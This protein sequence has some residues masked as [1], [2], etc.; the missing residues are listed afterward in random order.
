MTMTSR[1][2]SPS[3]TKSAFAFGVFAALGVVTWSG[4]GPGSESRYYCDSDGCYTCDAYGCSNVAPPQH[5][6]CS[7]QASCDPGQTCT[8]TGCATVC[9]DDTACVK[10]EVC[11][12]G[13]C[14]APGTDPGPAKECT[15]KADCGDGKTCVDS[16]CKACGGTDGPCPCAAETDCSGGLTCIAGACTAP[17]NGCKFTS[18]CENGKVCADGQCLTSC[19]SAPCAEGFTCT[20]GVCEPGTTGT[21]SCTTDPEC[22][23]GKFCDQGACVV[24]TRPKPNC[25]EDAQC[26]GTAATPKKCLGGFCKYTFTSDQYC[27]TIDSRIGYCAK[28]GVCRTQAEASAACVQPT[29]CAA[30]QSCIDNQCK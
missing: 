25:T 3:A 14:A 1:Y 8:A 24:D 20:K 26:G 17:Q 28:D 21:T 16:A 15:T 18:E 22:G 6:T 12:N 13:L 5:K 10:G 19:A 30:G 4:C 2:P 23:A 27:R 9:K 29:D 11:K 7:G